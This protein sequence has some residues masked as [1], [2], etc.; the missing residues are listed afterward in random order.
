[1]GPGR[2]VPEGAARRLQATGSRQKEEMMFVRRMIATS[3]AVAMA[4]FLAA[5]PALAAA[6]PAPTEKV[7]LNTATVEQLTALP[8]VGPTLAARIVEH[9]E[10]AG[11]FGSPQELM[12]VKGIGEKNFQKIEQWLTVEAPPRKASK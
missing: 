7:N 6:K 2:G 3:L 9:R 12:N 1:M 8:G 10:K 5:G 11:Q 4:V